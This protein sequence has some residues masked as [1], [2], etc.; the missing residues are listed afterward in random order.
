MKAAL[1]RRTL[2]MPPPSGPL[3][4]A[5]IRV[6]NAGPLGSR[7]FVETDG[8]EVTTTVISGLTHPRY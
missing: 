1:A 3:D 2:V 8:Q 7:R 6:R 4:E 5:P